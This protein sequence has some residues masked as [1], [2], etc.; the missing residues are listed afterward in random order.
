MTMGPDSIQPRVL[1][2]L[3]DAIVGPLLIIF[4]RS[5]QLGKIPKY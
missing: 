4:E 2:E 1:R 5:W 3:A